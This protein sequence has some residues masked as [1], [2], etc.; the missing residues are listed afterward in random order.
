VV[1]TIMAQT[2]GALRLSS[3]AAE[4]SDGFEAVLEL[5]G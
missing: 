5:A 1:A 3:P 4:W 2:G